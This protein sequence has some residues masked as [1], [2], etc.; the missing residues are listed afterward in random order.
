MFMTVIIPKVEFF[1]A[2]RGYEVP[3]EHD[4]ELRCAC[5]NPPAAVSILPQRS[6]KKADSLYVC[7]L[8][9]I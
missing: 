6:S 8:P 1:T 3:G 2:S 5:A 9:R 7:E 4:R